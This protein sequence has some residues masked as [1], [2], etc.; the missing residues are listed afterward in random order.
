MSELSIEIDDGRTTFAPGAQVAGRVSWRLTEAP[1][2]LSLRLFWQTAGRGTKDV[3]VV[4]ELA[5]GAGTAVGSAPFA[6]QLPPGPYSFSGRLVS[7]IWSLEL[8]VDAGRQVR[9]H[10]L[11][12]S[13]TGEE[14]RL[15]R[16]SDSD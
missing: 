1:R 14:V 9:R 15:V 8:L 12:V 4:E 5:L 16:D 13:P 10:N 7:V 2:G 11:V 6:L 3:R